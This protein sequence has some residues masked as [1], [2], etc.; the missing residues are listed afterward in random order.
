MGLYKLVKGA[1]KHQ[2]IVNGDLVTFNAGDTIETDRNLAESF[3]G[4]FQRLDVEELRKIKQPI[5]P[6]PARFIKADCLIADRLD[7][8]GLTDE[9]LIELTNSVSKELEKRQLKLEESE[10]GKLT[11]ETLEVKDVKAN[12]I[13]AKDLNK[14]VGSEV[15]SVLPDELPKV[16][17]KDKN[18]NA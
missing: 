10:S 18:K 11:L 15:K 8:S 13:Q 4:K 17:K 14:K 3:P 2:E 9:A 7:V 12:I 6:I 16:N 1:G 5:I